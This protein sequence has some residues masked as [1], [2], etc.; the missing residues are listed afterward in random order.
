MAT[1]GK[2]ISEQTLAASLDGNEII[3]FAKNGA[4]GAVKASKIK[5]WIEPDLSKLDSLPTATELD[6]ALTAKQDKLV[7]SADVTVGEDDKLNVT[8]EAKRKAFI[9]Q[10]NTACTSGAIRYGSYNEKTGY[11]E[12]N[13]LTD[14]SYEQALDI[15]RQSEIYSDSNVFGLY[16]SRT[17]Y[18]IRSNAT[19]YTTVSFYAK[20]VSSALEAIRFSYPPTLRAYAASMFANC[21]K[22]RVIHG[23]LTLASPNQNHVAGMFR[24]CSELREVQLKSLQTSISFSD[25]PL[26]SLDSISYMVTNAANTSPITITLHPDAYARL[27]DELIAQATEKQINFATET[28]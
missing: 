16:T 20:F 18:P 22:L 19:G 5:E 4:D 10:W 11:F 1:R 13:G 9:D 2:K 28:A 12:L 8:E 14:I 7:N 15:N 23:V 6:A 21:S 26:L 17:L 25:S 27:T 3:P 24:L